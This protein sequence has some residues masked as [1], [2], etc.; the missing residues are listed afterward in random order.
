M[1]YKFGLV[2]LGCSGALC[3]AALGGASSLSLTVGPRPAAGFGFA[4]KDYSQGLPREGNQS[5]FRPPLV[6]K[7]KTERFKSQSLVR[8]PQRRGVSRRLPLGGEV[9]L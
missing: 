5:D 3:G 6:K 4:P 9:G 1:S 2:E 7:T 8:L